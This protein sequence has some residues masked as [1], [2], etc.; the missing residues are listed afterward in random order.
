MT[1][2]FVPAPVISLAVKP[3][4]SS[5]FANFSKA[6]QRF[7]KVIEQTYKLHCDLATSILRV[8][9]L[10]FCYS[11]IC[12]CMCTYHH[13]GSRLTIT[14]TTTLNQKHTK[15]I[16]KNTTGGPDAAR[17]VRREDQGDGHL[18]HGVRRHVLAYAFIFVCMC[19]CMYVCVCEYDDGWRHQNVS[20][21]VPLLTP[22][23]I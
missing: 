23:Y 19:V 20:T 18:R 2:M 5:M 11:N 6:L 10:L 22:P 8:M 9:V 1:S 14:T 21:S 7:C 13:G 4:Q 3:K 16:T 15:K 17:G 12:I